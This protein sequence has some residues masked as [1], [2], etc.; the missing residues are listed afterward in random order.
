[1]KT[2]KLSDEMYNELVQIVDIT[3]SENAEWLKHCERTDGLKSCISD[4]KRDLTKAKKLLNKLY[5]VN[6]DE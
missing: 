1:M 3:V 4:A 5:E 6:E 2:I